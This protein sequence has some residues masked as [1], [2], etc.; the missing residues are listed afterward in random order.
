ME[1]IFSSFA[2]RHA[3]SEQTKGDKQQKSVAS[4]GGPSSASLF[5]EMAGLEALLFN[6]Q[7]GYLGKIVLEPEKRASGEG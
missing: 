4:P 3:S 2:R 5:P 6:A 7:D 1:V